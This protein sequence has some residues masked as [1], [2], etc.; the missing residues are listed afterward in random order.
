MEL[1]KRIF[2]MELATPKIPLSSLRQVVNLIDDNWNN[3]T[4]GE[5]KIDF[6]DEEKNIGHLYLR[7][8]NGQIGILVLNKDYRRRGI[9]TQILNLSRDKIIEY[10]KADTMWAVTVKDHGY[11]SNVPGMVWKEPAHESVTGSGYSVD[12]NN[13]DFV[14]FIKKY[15]KI[16]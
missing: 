1:F 15:E 3:V 11:W 10:G 16:N 4:N 12:I 13:K 14:D 6:F 5:T 7:Q 9:G 2:K 8:H